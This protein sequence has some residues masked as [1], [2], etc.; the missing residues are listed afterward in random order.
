MTHALD[1][2]NLTKSFGATRV[3]QEVSL[4]VAEGEFFVLLGPSGCGKTTL[5]RI[6]AGLEPMSRGDVSIRG[7]RVTD[8]PAEDRDIAMVFQDYALYPHMTARQNLEFGLKRRRM[9]KAEIQARVSRAAQT[10]GIDQLLDRKP[11]QLSGGQQQRV[12][13]GRA[14]VRQPK[15]FLMDEPLSNLDAQV[16]AAMRFE[17]KRLQRDLGV[18]TVYV[19]H[20]QVEAM[21]LGDRMAVI[22]AG[23]I[24]Q[25]GA[26]LDVYAKPANLFVGRFL[27]NPSLNVFPGSI[28]R[29]STTTVVC[30]PIGNFASGSNGTLASATEKVDVGVRPENLRVTD[31]ELPGVPP[32]DVLLVEPLGAELLV[33]ARR[34]TVDVV[35]RVPVDTLPL[36]AKKVWIRSAGCHLHLFDPQTGQALAHFTA[37]E[38]RES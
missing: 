2:V 5:L 37:V 4:E 20:D 16:R 10:L 32:L 33:Y 34:E 19:T 31:R 22:N 21:T 6:I 30:T 12:A 11:R 7:Q 35:L 38:E 36:D 9:P 26:P 15:L 18:A 28:E 27:G 23:R 13:L 3:L 25:I 14:I 29:K 8:T 24:E 17:L 1:V